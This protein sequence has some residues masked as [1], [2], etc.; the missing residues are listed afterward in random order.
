MVTIAAP[1]HGWIEGLRFRLCFFW[2]EV[3]GLSFRVG[4]LGLGGRFFFLPKASVVGF[5]V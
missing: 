1:S 5:G 4:D 2:A 3:L